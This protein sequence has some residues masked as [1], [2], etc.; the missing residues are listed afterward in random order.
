M[1][2]FAHT[3]DPFA[4]FGTDFFGGRDARPPIVLTRPL[5]FAENAEAGE[6]IG[7]VLA[8]DGFF[9]S[10][11][12]EISLAGPDSDLFAV[13]DGGTVR[14]T[15][16]GA[17][18]AIN[19]FE[20]GANRA[21]VRVTATDNAGNT[22]RARP[23]TIETRNDPA[24]DAPADLPDDGSNGD[25]EATLDLNF[26]SPELDGARD[27]ITRAFEDAWSAWTQHFDLAADAAIDIAVGT[28]DGGGRGAIASARPSFVDTGET[29]ANGDDLV[30]S[31]VVAELRDGRERS[32]D[33]PDARIDF[34][35]D[36]SNFAF[37]DESRA[38]AFDAE[39]ILKHELGHVLGFATT[40]PFDGR[41]TALEAGTEEDFLSGPTFEGERAGEVALAD[42]AHTASGLMAPAIAPATEREIGETE[43]AVLADIGV[44]VAE[45]AL[46][47]SDRDPF[48]V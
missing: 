36:L 20:S 18:A 29:A 32:P 23:L 41:S 35:Q 10:G 48:V 19:D 28:S 27:A 24:D 46:D 9:G 42:G 47:T 44:P 43:L 33:Q 8:L 3:D 14:L 13:D 34:G 7:Q 25:G 15:D 17:D 26:V 2:F 40:R 31:Q 1:R 6:A 16:A 5:A 4:A 38:G 39:T 21:T 22:S 12:A 37:G 45:D 30:R 11:V